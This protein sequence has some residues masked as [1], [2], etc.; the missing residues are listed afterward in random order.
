MR[1]RD[2]QPTICTPAASM[3]CKSDFKPLLFTEQHVK[4]A[5]QEELSPSPTQS[6]HTHPAVIARMGFLPCSHSH[7]LGKPSLSLSLQARTP[8]TERGLYQ[9]AANFKNKLKTLLQ[10]IWPHL[11]YSLSNHGAHQAFATSNQM[12]GDKKERQERKGLRWCQE[13]LSLQL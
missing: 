9:T 10:I 3:V 7:E 2:R 6:R 12:A 13:G 8:G 11:C 5:R 4:Q 1:P